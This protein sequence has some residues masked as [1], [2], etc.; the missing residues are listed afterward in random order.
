MD[1]DTDQAD[2]DEVPFDPE[3]FINNLGQFNPGH[4]NLP[5]GKK[6]DQQIRNDLAN[7]LGAKYSR[8]LQGPNSNVPSDFEERAVAKLREAFPG[9]AKLIENLARQTKLIE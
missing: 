5:E 4:V 2:V 9:Q 7:I 8:I 3:D 1:Y 6:Q